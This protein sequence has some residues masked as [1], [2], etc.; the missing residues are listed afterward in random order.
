MKLRAGVGSGS[1]RG[2]SPTG[3]KQIAKTFWQKQPLGPAAAWPSP[4]GLEGLQRRSYAR[5]GDDWG[6]NTKNTFNC[7]RLLV[8]KSSRLIFLSGPL[9]SCRGSNI[10]PLFQAR[11]VSPVIKPQTH[12]GFVFPTHRPGTVPVYKTEQE[13]FSKKRIFFPFSFQRMCGPRW[14]SQCSRLKNIQRCSQPPPVSA[15]NTKG[16]LLLLV[17]LFFF[18]SIHLSVHLLTAG[19]YLPRILNNFVTFPLDGGI[20]NNKLH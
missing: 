5:V 17:F 18:L 12:Y 14:V 1:L 8:Q 2:P 10:C 9:R 3:N 13:K 16:R 7:F 4:T 19:T 20:H 15:Q 11:T 6:G